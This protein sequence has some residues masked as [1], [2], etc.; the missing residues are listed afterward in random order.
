MQE[1]TDTIDA[2]FVKEIFKKVEEAPEFKDYVLSYVV[3][4]GNKQVESQF[5]H[6]VIML[7]QNYRAGDVL[8]VKPIHRDGDRYSF[9]FVKKDLSNENNDEYALQKDF[10]YLNSYIKMQIATGGAGSNRQKSGRLLQSDID[11][12][13]ATYVIDRDGELHDLMELPI[14]MLS[15][16][17]DPNSAESFKTLFLNAKAN[18]KAWCDLRRKVMTNPKGEKAQYVYAIVKPELYEKWKKLSSRGTYKQNMLSLV[19]SIRLDLDQ[20]SNACDSYVLVD[21]NFAMGEALTKKNKAFVNSKNKTSVCLI[22]SSLFDKDLFYDIYCKAY[23]DFGNYY[24]IEDIMYV[25]TKKEI[26]QITDYLNDQQTKYLENPIT[27][28]EREINEIRK[29]VLVDDIYK[30]PTQKAAPKDNSSEQSSDDT[31]LKRTRRIPPQSPMESWMSAEKMKRLEQSISKNNQSIIDY[32]RTIHP[33]VKTDLPNFEM[34]SQNLAPLLSYYNNLDNLRKRLNYRDP[35]SNEVISMKNVYDMGYSEK[36]RENIL[37]YYG[38]AGANIYDRAYFIEFTNYMLDTYKASGA[39]YDITAFSNK[40]LPE[41]K[42]Q[43]QIRM[44]NKNNDIPQ[45]LR[46]IMD[47]ALEKGSLDEYI[48][49]IQ[50]FDGIVEMQNNMDK[51][52]LSKI[53]T[54]KQQEQ[55]IQELSDASF[56]PIVET[57]IHN[58]VGNLITPWTRKELLEIGF[59]KDDSVI[60]WETTPSTVR[61]QKMRNKLVESE[62][63]V[64]RIKS[65]KIVPNS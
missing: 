54:K 25:P 14:A 13:N 65:S 7:G 31:P 56:T 52:E 59:L 11:R 48:K 6:S 35:F 43:D 37:N 3:Y 26:E 29:S 47:K 57:E 45:Q 18:S 8:Y 15:V 34:G 28:T 55:T 10:A 38:E 50:R 58:A 1:Y 22:G 53:K 9:I 20:A 30:K 4:G 23:N 12:A 60:S 16:K 49:L 41:S 24:P 33:H 36:V 2:K 40:L 64:E 21:P 27:L 44:C 63:K 46:M 32:I 19:N 42:E 62:E 5:N 61:Q 51:S 17:D 39:L